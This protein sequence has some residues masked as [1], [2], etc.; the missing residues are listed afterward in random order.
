MSCPG[1]WADSCNPSSTAEA[2]CSQTP[3]QY[4]IIGFFAAK[5]INV[6]KPNQVAGGTGQPF[7]NPNVPGPEQPIRPVYSGF[8]ASQP[9]PV[10]HRVPPDQDLQ[11]RD[12]QGQEEPPGPAPVLGTDYLVDYTRSWRPRGDLI[13]SGPRE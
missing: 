5:L 10:L 1:T 11:R 2:A 7:C 13:P 9:K 12:R 8:E 4:D 6:Y 3:G